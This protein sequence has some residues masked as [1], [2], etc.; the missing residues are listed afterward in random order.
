MGLGTKPAA[1]RGGA[2][3]RLQQSASFNGYLLLLWPAPPSQL[4]RASATT[5]TGEALTLRLDYRPRCLFRRCC[6]SS[7]AGDPGSSSSPTLIPISASLAASIVGWVRVRRSR[8]AG[9]AVAIA[10][11]ASL[12]LIV[13]RLRTLLISTPCR[14]RFDLLHAGCPATIAGRAS[15]GLRACRAP[16]RV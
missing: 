11:A 14:L 13:S 16:R 6:R 10:V 1:F 3:R 9:H 7:R 8:P 12:P 4:R 2:G 5:T 15:A